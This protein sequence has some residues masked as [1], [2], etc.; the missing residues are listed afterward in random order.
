MPKVS[1]IIP[2]YNHSAFIAA[3]IDSVL[4]QSYRDFEIIVVND[5]SPDATEEVL[6]PYI[7]SGKIHYIWQENLGPAA[8]RNR[9]VEAAE[10]EFIAFLDDDDQWMPDKLEW[11]LSCFDEAD[12]VM[13][14]GT[15]VLLGAPSKQ[16][17]GLRKQAFDVLKLSDFFRGNPVGSP[18][19]A[20]LRKS[21]LIRVGGFDGSIW[22]ADDLDL[23]I[24]LSQL[25]E[26]R[27]YPRPC[28]LYRQHA[29]NASMDFRRM[30]INTL[31]VISRHI[32]SSTGQSQR[33]HRIHAYRFLF[34]YTGRK[35]LWEAA[36]HWR[37]G[38]RKEAR[39]ALKEVHRVFRA[40]ILRDPKLAF[41]L[42]HAAIKTPWKLHKHR[43]SDYRRHGISKLEDAKPHHPI[44]SAS[45]DSPHLPLAPSPRLVEC[46]KEG[47]RMVYLPNP[48]NLGDE[49]IAAATTMLFARIGVC[50]EIFDENAEYGEG[51]TLIYGGGGACVPYW[52]ILD[53]LK[54][55]FTMPGIGRCII[56]PHSI[57]DCPDLLSV[58]DSRF[59]VFCREQ[60]SFDYCRSK[61]QQAEFVL[62]DDMAL[63]L[64]LNHFP[65]I[66]DEERR[67]P[68]LLKVFGA[69]LGLFS[70]RKRARIKA[71][72]KLDHKT[73]R[74]MLKHLGN[75]VRPFGRDLKIAWFMRRDQEK[76][77][78]IGDSLPNAPFM[79]LS[80]YGGGD[81][82]DELVNYL[83]V[84]LFLHAI[85]EVDVVVTDRLHVGVGAAL[86]G[87]HLVWLDNSYGKVHGVFQN[88]MAHIPHIH[89][90]HSK[91]ELDAVLKDLASSASLTCRHPRFQSLGVPR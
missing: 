39:D 38:R 21:V 42:L 81:C 53:K 23:W 61:N 74:R 86:L 15:S 62:S 80:R 25:G 2:A 13:V 40:A 36:R 64:D 91:M 35:L 6:R 45:F 18:G 1:V 65:S 84:E 82:V 60:A 41:S 69:S 66:S 58:M 59:T 87:K 57:R 63:S 27:R 68:S 32:D 8:A 52:N 72:A 16:R 77:D 47:G 48:G 14:A 90:V 56:L 83:G 5:G 78:V 67:A 46:L 29:S 89:F 7:E 9:G 33:R 54:A 28:L 37:E 51:W 43:N 73:R 10:G 79:D 76:T 71:L 17:W 34:R 75:H 20:L 24:R 55:I 12:V 49:M 88:S 19:Q 44:E 85:N 50:Y 11:Q 26:I 3:A 30:G 22:G 4:A 70:R 31:K